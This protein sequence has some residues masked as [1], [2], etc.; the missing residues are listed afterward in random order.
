[1]GLWDDLKRFFGGAAPPKAGGLAGRARDAMLSKAASKTS[2]EV[3]DI[4]DAVGA[5][6]DE[7]SPHVE[8]YFAAGLL[9]EF[10][11]RR[12]AR[13]TGTVLF[14]PYTGA[15]P[16]ERVTTPGV[17]SPPL[18]PKATSAPTTPGSSPAPV[19][20]AYA[21]NPEI[22]GL[23]L[24][25][26]RKRAL[27]VVPWRTAW[28]GRVDTIPPQSDE[29]TALID[30]GLLLRGLLTEAQ[31]AEIHTIGDQWLEHHDAHKLAKVKAQKSAD[32]AIE[33][34]KE[35]KRRAKEAKKQAAAERRAKRAEAI[36]KRRAED[37]IFLG[38]SVS[39]GLADRRS[40][41]ERL[42][43]LG[44]PRLSSPADVAKAL[45]LTVSELRWLCFH[46]EAAERT[47]YVTFDIPKRSG[48]VRRIAAPQQMLAAAQHWVLTQVLEKLP[49][50]NQAHGFVKGRSTVTNATV[51]LQSKVV[52][53]LDLKDFFPSITFPRVK[54]VFR[55][56]GY[57]PAVATV[58]AL[59]CTEAPR[60]V[61]EYDG[62]RLHVAVGARAL[63]QG[64]CTSP[65]ISNQ[66]ARRLD[67]R[68]VGRL[69]KKGWVYTRYADDLT[70]S[71]KTVGREAVAWLMAVV[72][73]VAQEEGFALNPDKGRVNVAAG[74]QVVTGLVVNQAVAVPRS[75][76]KRLRALLH[77]AKKT[78]LAAQN[79]TEHPA[80]K[81][82]VQGMVAYVSMANEKHGAALQKALDA[83]R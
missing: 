36:A 67:R 25:A 32:A 69:S 1:M 45:E 30:R 17:T 10:G 70:F 60:R 82:A 76:R 78:G 37:I 58:L 33:A 28:I 57:S 75:E 40:N 61:V 39:S 3:K 47:H 42:E 54:G 73:H 56:C 19:R 55:R 27:K 34:L 38:P 41:L 74:Q 68:L 9:D 20:G 22:L 53:N 16:G 48:G 35:E 11:Y 26:M 18:Q 79:R 14:N 2:F 8:Q 4:A 80:F 29:R 50:E 44:L 83:V 23:S 72:R 51:H 12:W 64:A 62:K 24:E 13:D 77:Q 43:T 7:V 52:V 5:S 46:S 71:S 66:I 65:A 81:D 63:P 15:R 49:V 21:A 31:L 6:V 59:L